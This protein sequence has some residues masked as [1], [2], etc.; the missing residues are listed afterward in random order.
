MKL[1][2][3]GVEGVSFIQEKGVE[4]KRSFLSSSRAPVL[5]EIPPT[6]AVSTIFKTMGDPDLLHHIWIGP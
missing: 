3:F 6:M 4:E 2:L 1:E 5:F